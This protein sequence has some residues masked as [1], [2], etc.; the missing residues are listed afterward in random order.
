[1]AERPVA[2]YGAGGH[3]KVVLDALELNGREIV[4][5]LDDDSRR[6]GG[7]HCGYPVLAA[8]AAMELGREVEFVIAIGDAVARR[9]TAARVA[10]HG[11]DLATAVHPSAVVARDARVVP[12]AMILAAAV[13]NPGAY[14]GACVIVN[15]GAIIDHDCVIGD[16]AHVAPG[17]RL[18]GGVNV[19]DGALIG[20]G[21]SVVPGVTIGTGAVVG[22]GAVV[23]ADVAPGTTV[24][25][26]PAKPV[27]RPDS[28]RR[29]V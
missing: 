2:I 11:R 14:L 16:F 8:A 12:G 27:T 9:Q 17:A 20:V 29:L 3:G 15:T 24:V 28:G 4:G 1:M 5:F 23:I 25:G 22:A 19:G 26:N 6:A 10:E 13:V 7:K 21:A 18:A